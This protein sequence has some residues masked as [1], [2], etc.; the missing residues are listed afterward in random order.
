MTSP[1]GPVCLD[2]EAVAAETW[3]HVQ[4]EVEDLLESGFSV[5]EEHVHTLAAQPR[6]SESA[7]DAV[8]DPPDVCARFLVQVLQ[9]NGMQSWHDED[10]ARRHRSEVHERDDA[11]VCIR[12][13]RLGLSGDDRAE[14]AFLRLLVIHVLSVA[15]SGLISSLHG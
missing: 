10:V 5:G 15:A 6:T 14:D 3:K 1:S 13:A 7:A 12:H 9:S 8:A 11:I 4:M 2:A